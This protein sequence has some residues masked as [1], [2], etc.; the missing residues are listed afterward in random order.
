MAV[1]IVGLLAV[2]ALA[3]VVVALLG[4]K[5]AEMVRRVSLGATILN[6]LLAS[7]LAVGFAQSRRQADPE[8]EL[9]GTTFQPEMTD[10]WNLITLG[11]QAGGQ[12]YSSAM[13]F[14]VGCDGLN[15]WLIVL[16]AVLMVSG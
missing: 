9:P 4:Q 11:N 10:T 15:I 12:N 6:L 14:F 2:P 8:S 1:L 3:A 13:Q 7:V 16:T 5:R